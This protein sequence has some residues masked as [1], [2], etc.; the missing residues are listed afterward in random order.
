[1]QYTLRQQFID[2]ESNYP[3]F[4]INGD[5]IEKYVPN[6][7]ANTDYQRIKKDYAA[8]SENEKPF[9]FNFQ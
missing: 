4:L 2:G 5:G 8:L 3:F 6:D 9:V 1:M 7:P